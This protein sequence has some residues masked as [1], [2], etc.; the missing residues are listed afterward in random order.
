MA[1][2]PGP[3]IV[4]GYEIVQQDCDSTFPPLTKI[5]NGHGNLNMETIDAN[6]RLLAAAP[7]LLAALKELVHYD[8]GSS[9]QGSFGYEALGR[10]KSAI[11][12]AE[13]VTMEGTNGKERP[14]D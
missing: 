4:N 9:A 7:E 14:L 1:H 10:C 5:C 3:W 8:E 6:A 11:A 2:T 13:G 12:K